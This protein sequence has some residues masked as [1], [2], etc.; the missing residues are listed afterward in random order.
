[1]LGL[2]ACKGQISV[3]GVS[4]ATDGERFRLLREVEHGGKDALGRH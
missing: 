4:A 2:Q 3:E 1:M